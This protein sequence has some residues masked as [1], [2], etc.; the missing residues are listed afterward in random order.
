MKTIKKVTKDPK[1][2]NA[3]ITMIY[4]IVDIVKSIISVIKK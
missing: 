1:K 2:V 3:I 4:K